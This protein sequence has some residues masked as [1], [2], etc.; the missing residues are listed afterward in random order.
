MNVN[1]IVHIISKKLRSSILGEKLN[2]NVTM[3]VKSNF[4]SAILKEDIQKDIKNVEPE[5]TP[6]MPPEKVKRY[7]ERGMEEVAS[8]ISDLNFE[9]GEN[10]SPK[11]IKLSK[12][13]LPEEGGA[14]IKINKIMGLK[15]EEVAAQI[16]PKSHLF[17]L[18]PEFAKFISYEIVPPAALSPEVTIAIKVKIPK[19]VLLDM[20]GED[21]GWSKTGK[22]VE[23]YGKELA[24]KL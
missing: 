17:N 5:V 23:K 21:A 16:I 15:N 8:I 18:R 3:L 6:T 10:L 20:T 12:V 4:N 2:E 19:E 11:S 13:S 22:V 7:I 14:I 1:K 24:K 9:L